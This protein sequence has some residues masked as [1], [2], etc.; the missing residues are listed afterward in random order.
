MN[1]RINHRKGKS[2]V[3]KFNNFEFTLKFDS[4]GD[5]F[6]V[7]FYFD[8]KNKEHAELAC[9]SHFHI[10]ELE[11]NGERLITGYILSQNFDREPTKQLAE[12]GG[13][14]LPGV[15]EDCQIPPTN[16]PLQSDN[17]SLKEI[18]E[19]FIKDFRLKLKVDPSVAAAANK[20]IEKTAATNTQTIKSY[21]T[22]LAVQR[23]I[24]ITHDEMGNLLLTSAKTNLPPLFKL[25]KSGSIPGTKWGLRFN[26]QGIHSHIWIVKQAS[27][28][29]GNAGQYLIRNPYCPVAA[30]FRPRV[31]TM[32]SGDDISVEDFG[33]QILAD[34]LKNIQLVVETDRWEI[35]GKIVRPNN[36]IK[37]NDPEVFLYKETTWFIESI[38]YKGDEEK[39]VASY[40]CV[41][42]EVY[43]KQTPKNI[44]VDPHADLPRF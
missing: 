28:K 8:P 23:G 5:T 11:H 29:G 35:D 39:T 9:V 30:V 19:K 26:G 6:G 16:Y 41:P 22:E 37:V 34:E 7:K 25:L 4:V 36:V 14:S 3:T 40:V 43:N 24:I 32:N 12:L 38:T 13:Y 17:L 1:L 15:L 33:K 2:N 21:F 42:P 31:E 10:A 44:F 27:S 20:K 18:I